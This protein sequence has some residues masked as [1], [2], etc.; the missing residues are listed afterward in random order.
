MS[1]YEDMLKVLDGSS[2]LASAVDPDNKESLIAIGTVLEKAFQM[3]MGSTYPVAEPCQV[4]LE[5]VQKI[6]TDECAEPRQAMQAVAAA[7]T[8][9]EGALA[10]G[11]SLSGNDPFKD[12]M[13][14]LRS[15]AEGRPQAGGDRAGLRECFY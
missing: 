8:A 14:G 4:A 3:A 13:A 2:A 5:I 7:M 11:K 15:A 9:V 10:S 6:F 1:A 12:V